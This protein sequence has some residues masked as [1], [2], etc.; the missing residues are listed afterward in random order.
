MSE[1]NSNIISKTAEE[2]QSRLE[3]QTTGGKY[4]LKQ[5]RTMGI[6]AVG[7]VAGFFAFGT[8][9]NT[10]LPE[11]IAKQF[12]PGEHLQEFTEVV[13]N[14]LKWGGAFVG[15]I[16]SSM[17]CT[18][19]H[20]KSVESEKLAVA[21]MNI[22]LANMVEQRNQFA[23]TLNHQEQIIKDLVAER[24]G[25]QTAPKSENISKSSGAGHDGR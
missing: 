23:T 4:V 25:K 16:V 14:N 22:D 18:Y 3:E 17:F 12:K 11:W 10:K 21:E 19:E 5:L 2:R 6:M 7:A 24:Q 15:T 9:K 20:W 13:K 8:L 1:N